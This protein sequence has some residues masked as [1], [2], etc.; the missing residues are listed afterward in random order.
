[1]QTPEPSSEAGLDPSAAY[2]AS[3]YKQHPEVTQGFAGLAKYRP[4][5]IEGYLTM[6]RAW[7]VG[8]PSR[9]AR[10][11]RRSPRRSRSASRSPA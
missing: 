5:V 9:P 8:G 3:Y 11:S 2:Q 6:R 10:P 7:P 4:E 1:M